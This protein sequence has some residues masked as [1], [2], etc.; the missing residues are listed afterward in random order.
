MKATRILVALVA[1]AVLVW[2]GLALALPLGEKSTSKKQMSE[3]PAEKTKEHAKAGAKSDEP[4]WGEAVHIT[5]GR[6]PETDPLPP[7]SKAY[8]KHIRCRFEAVYSGVPRDRADDIK[9]TIT[10]AGTETIRKLFAIVKFA[11]PPGEPKKT[12]ADT[13]EKPNPAGAR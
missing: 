7:Q 4:A 12:P 9:A 10:N 1:V 2:A 11:R 13:R 8:A 3:S 6:P 5:F